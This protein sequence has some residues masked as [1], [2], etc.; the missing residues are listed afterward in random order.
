MGKYLV[1]PPALGVTAKELYTSRTVNTG[2]S[3]T[4][5][6]VPD[7]N[8]FAGKYEPLITPYISNSNISTNYSST[9][10]F[11][12]G[13][14]A[15]VAAY[16]IAYLNGKQTPTIERFDLTGGAVG[17]GFRGYMDF[18]IAEQDPRGAVRA[19]GEAAAS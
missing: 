12:F 15:D 13:D 7:A 6:K 1:V 5:T 2:G 17:I 10:Y 9:L 11:L 4:K 18:G 16:D 3:S 14:P 8:V 19:T